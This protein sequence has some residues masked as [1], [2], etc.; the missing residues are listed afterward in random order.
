LNQRNA[1]LPLPFPRT[2]TLSHLFEFVKEITGKKTF[3]L[4]EAVD[5]EYEKTNKVNILIKLD[6][7]GRTPHSKGV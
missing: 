1:P 7:Y 3:Y 4:V 6:I 2:D 5:K